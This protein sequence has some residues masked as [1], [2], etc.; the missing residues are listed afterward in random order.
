[1]EITQKN[2]N[3]LHLI[4]TIFVQEKDYATQVDNILKNYRKKA[5]IKGFRKGN[6]PIG[7]IKKRYYDAVRIDEVNKLLEKKLKAYIVDKKLNILGNPLPLFK[8]NINWNSKSIPFEFEIGLSPEFEL[9]LKSKALIKYN[10]TISDADIDKD[11]ALIK[12][13]YGKLIPKKEI[14]EASEIKADFENEKLKIKTP[15]AY[16]TILDIEKQENINTLK[17]SKIGDAINIPLKGFFKNEIRLS[18]L[19]NMDKNTLEAYKDEN[20]TL[21]IKEIYERIPTHLDQHLFDRLYGEKVVT[22]EK[23]MRQKIKEDRES[24]FKQQSDQYFYNTVNENLIANTPFELPTD[25]LKKWIKS[26]QKEANADVDKEI[27]TQWEGLIKKVRYELI[28]NKIIEENKLEISEIEIESYVT[29][30]VENQIKM[31]GKKEG[32]SLE[33]N[34][35]VNEILENK[36]ETKRFY[37]QLMFQKILNFYTTQIPFEEKKITYDKF[38]NEI[39]K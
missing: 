1:M 32:D 37:N 30:A 6:V 18:Q 25:F 35:I 27:K 17:N 34:K 23:E 19:L 3:P 2:I 4:L 21:T 20:I 10:I 11:I 8:S 5:E 9:D 31:I 22:S 14:N 7:L 13:Q 15:D 12:K 29:K 26:S 24:N 16:F 33:V 39:K 36:N 28:E 38:L